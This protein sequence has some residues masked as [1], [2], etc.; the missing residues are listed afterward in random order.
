[1]WVLWAGIIGNGWDGWAG[2]GRN[3]GLRHL[4]CFFLLC[5]YFLGKSDGSVVLWVG[6]SIIEGP[7]KLQ[8]IHDPIARSSQA[9]YT[10]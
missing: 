6:S 5:F 1:M 8:Q 3:E 7:T 4:T 2:I 10:S 9:F